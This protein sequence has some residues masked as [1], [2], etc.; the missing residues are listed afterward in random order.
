MSIYPVI[1]PLFQIGSTTDIQPGQQKKVPG[2]SCS[3]SPPSSNGVPVSAIPSTGAFQKDVKETRES[4]SESGEALLSTTKV[5]RKY[6]FLLY[7][8]ILIHLPIKTI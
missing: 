3:G 6:C 7:V 2:A 8:Y 5:N 1:R 4:L